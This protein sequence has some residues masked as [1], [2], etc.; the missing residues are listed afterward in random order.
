MKI[1][2]KV[3]GILYPMKNEV[4]DLIGTI[5][6][7]QDSS[8]PYLVRFDNWDKGH[9]GYRGSSKILEGKCPYDGSKN[10]WW[11]YPEEIKLLNKYVWI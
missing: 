11:C 9:E 7:I 2:D 1:N 10:H 3:I 8:Q 4:T 6:A 5:V